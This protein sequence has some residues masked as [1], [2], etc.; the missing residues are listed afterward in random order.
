M[1][2]MK[3]EQ[4]IQDYKNDIIYENDS[5]GLIMLDYLFGYGTTYD[6]DNNI[7]LSNTWCGHCGEYFES[8]GRCNYYCE[9]CKSKED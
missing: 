6:G 9:K 3:E 1:Y 4:I 5:I 2:K 8:E 7:I